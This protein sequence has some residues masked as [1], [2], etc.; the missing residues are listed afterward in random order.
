MLDVFAKIE[1]SFLKDAVQF[2]ILGNTYKDDRELLGSYSFIKIY[3]TYEAENLD[4]ILD[5][6]KLHVVLYHQSG[7]KRM[8]MLV[9][10][11]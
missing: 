9:L 2:Y 5:E 8:V 4:K 7:K 3:G 10:S 6:L 11:Y 1:V